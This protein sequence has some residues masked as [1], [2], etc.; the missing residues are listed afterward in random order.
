MLY[1]NRGYR[2]PHSSLL[3]LNDDLIAL[4]VLEAVALCTVVTSSSFDTAGLYLFVEL[5][6]AWC[7]AAAAANTALVHR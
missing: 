3:L 6:G 7:A 1:R 5:V 4:S 2:Y